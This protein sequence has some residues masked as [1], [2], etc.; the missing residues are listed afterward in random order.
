[1]NRREYLDEEGLTIVEFSDD[2]FEEVLKENLE[3]SEIIDR[4]ERKI[5][6][7]QKNSGKNIWHNIFETVLVFFDEEFKWDGFKLNYW[8]YNNKPVRELMELILGFYND[9]Y[10]H[11]FE[12][13]QMI[14]YNLQRL[15][16]IEKINLEIDE[17]SVGYMEAYQ[18][19]LKIGRHEYGDNFEN[20]Q[21]NIENNISDLEDE[22]KT[23]ERLKSEKGKIQKRSVADDLLEDLKALREKNKDME[24]VPKL[25]FMQMDSNNVL[26][27]EDELAEL[28]ISFLA[29][30]KF[31]EYLYHKKSNKNYADMLQDLIEQMN[32]NKDICYAWEKLTNYNAILLI[33]KFLVNCAWNNHESKKEKKQNIKQ[34]IEA[35]MPLFRQIF[36]ME[37]YLTRLVLLKQV[38]GYVEAN[39]QKYTSQLLHEFMMFLIQIND[40][41]K[42][43]QNQVCIY[44]VFLRWKISLKSSLDIWKTELQE[45]YPIGLLKK[46]LIFQNLSKMVSTSELLVMPKE[47]EK[48]RRKQLLWAKPLLKLH[49]QSQLNDYE[50]IIKQ[51]NDRNFNIEMNSDWRYCIKNYS[52]VCAI[53]EII[54]ENLLSDSDKLVEKMESK[55]IVAGKALRVREE[56]NDSQDMYIDTPFGKIFTEVMDESHNNCTEIYFENNYSEL[57]RLVKEFWISDN[58]NIMLE[59]TYLRNISEN[60]LKDVINLILYQ[61]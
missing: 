16:K 41:Y 43:W 31:Q 27:I 61:I 4:M 9:T 18:D 2:F 47:K 55:G 6:E 22:Y 28:N 45:E 7:K 46:M 20:L 19:L 49:F 56:G 29:N 39:E 38:F 10:F 13:A 58:Q 54:D 53:L 26:Y 17:K 42:N 11:T 57:K 51:L 5:K 44:A 21:D 37:N 8:D 40:T 12:I 23:A 3:F 25:R 48:T 35:Q 33:A 1:M 15:G 34:I 60:D 14:K 59:G 36:S 30:E 32:D 52:D 24:S 50:N